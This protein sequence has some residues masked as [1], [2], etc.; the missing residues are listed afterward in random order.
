M[1]KPH[2]VTETLIKPC[3]LKMVKAVLGEEAAKNLNRFFVGQ[4][5]RIRIDEIGT[6]DLDQFCKTS[7]LF[8]PRSQL[9]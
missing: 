5:I 7:K 8:P 2:T 6:N 1:K 3:V 9:S 4:C